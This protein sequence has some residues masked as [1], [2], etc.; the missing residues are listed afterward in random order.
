MISKRLKGTPWYDW[1]ALAIVILI[2]TSIFLAVVHGVAP[3]SGLEKGLHNAGQQIAGIFR[4]IADFFLM[5]A[6]W[7]ASW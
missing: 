6:N 3:N 7:F 5:C 4:W 2:V 1:I